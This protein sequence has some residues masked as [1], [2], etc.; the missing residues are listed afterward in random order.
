MRVFGIAVIGLAVLAI[1]PSGA[2]GGPASASLDSAQ[3]TLTATDT[4]WSTS[5]GVTNLTNA[6]LELVAPAVRAGCTPQVGD[7]STFLP[8]ALHETV[9]VSIPAQCKAGDGLTFVLIARGGGA[10]QSFTVVAAPKKMPAVFWSSLLSFL[11]ALGAAALLVAAVAITWRTRKKWPGELAGLGATWSFKDS[12]VSNVTAGS[13]LVAV[14]LGSSDFLKAVLGSDAESAIAVATIAGAIALA[15]VGAA[16]VVVIMLKKTGKKDIGATGLCA[17]YVVAFGAAGG[18][19]WAVSLLVLSLEI[20]TWPTRIVWIAAIVTSLLLAT[21]A[22][23]S[24]WDLLVQGTADNDTDPLEH[25][26]PVEVVAAAVSV[27]ANSQHVTRSDVEGVLSLLQKKPAGATIVH[28]SRRA[29][30]LGWTTHALANRS[31]MP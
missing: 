27:A 5:V 17:G 16:G 3:L 26:L 14:V 30:E 22:A 25:P 13:G 1:A 21:Y 28:R 12:I 4:G 18:Q 19:V 2:L 29:V 9:T 15:L 8:A 23:R 7:G 24:L 10:S 11:I 31:A 20:G 6:Q